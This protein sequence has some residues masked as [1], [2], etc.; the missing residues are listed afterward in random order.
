[1]SQ[2]NN[3]KFIHFRY[4][5]SNGSFKSR[6]GRT[7]AYLETAPGEF[8]VGL[9]KCHT[10][11]NFN[12]SLARARAGGRLNSVRESQVFKG[13]YEELLTAA[14]REAASYGMVRKFANKPK[15]QPASQ[16][17]LVATI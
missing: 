6:G 15:E 12:K 17:G 7:V 10:N 14:T 5:E 2:N 13:T 9:S 1:M 8:R 11:D 3:V 4:P 16:T